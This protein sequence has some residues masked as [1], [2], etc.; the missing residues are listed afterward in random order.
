MTANVIRVVCPQILPIFLL[1]LSWYLPA[2]VQSFNTVFGTLSKLH[3][4][5]FCRCLTSFDSTSTGRS[6]TK[7]SPSTVHIF[8]STGYYAA[9]LQLAGIIK[10]S[11]ILCAKV[12]VAVIEPHKVSVQKSSGVQCS[13][14]RG[15]SKTRR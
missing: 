3:C 6:D 9:F 2:E 1:S 14:E 13:S 4:R 15:V 12:A 10:A 11:N 7:R 5:R 8:L